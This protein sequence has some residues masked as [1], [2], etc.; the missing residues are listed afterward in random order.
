MF[1]NVFGGINACDQVAR[2]IIGAL[3]DAGDAAL[4][5]VVRSMATRSRMGA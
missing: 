5:L 4:L 3:R 2:G 1:V